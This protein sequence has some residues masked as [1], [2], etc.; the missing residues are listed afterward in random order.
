VYPKNKTNTFHNNK[1]NEQLESLEQAVLDGASFVDQET[2]QQIVLQGDES[3]NTYP[4]TVK[5][6]DIVASRKS[7]EPRIT[8]SN[9]VRTT[10]KI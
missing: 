5:E 6:C 3:S 2:P 4:I 7:S 1:S 9:K 8:A 10:K